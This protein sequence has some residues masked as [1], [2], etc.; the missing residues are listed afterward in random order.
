M[1]NGG[2]PG[3]AP[4]AATRSLPTA[5]TLSRPHSQP[6]ANPSRLRAKARQVRPQLCPRRGVRG[7]AHRGWSAM[8]HVPRVTR[9]FV[10]SG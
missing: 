5:T 7:C 10:E 8:S 1:A 6:D 3:L 4:C 9:L 2:H